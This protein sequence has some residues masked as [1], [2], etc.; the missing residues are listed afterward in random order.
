MYHFGLPYNNN[1]NIWVSIL[2]SPYFGKLPCNGAMDF[3][4]CLSWQVLPGNHLA[5]LAS[6]ETA[7][8]VGG[9]RG[10]RSTEVY[11]FWNVFLMPTPPCLLSEGEAKQNCCRRM[12]GFQSSSISLYRRYTSPATPLKGPLILTNPPCGFCSRWG[13]ARNL[14]FGSSHMF[15]AHGSG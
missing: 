2:R 10:S 12:L 14:V 4:G 3:V 11:R 1:Y 6:E 8:S 13:Q 7:G 15:P 5:L 9:R